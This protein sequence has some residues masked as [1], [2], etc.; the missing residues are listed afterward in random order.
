M[1]APEEQTAVRYLIQPGSPVPCGTG[2]QKVKLDTYRKRSVVW[3]FFR[4]INEGSVQCVLCNRYLHKKEHGSTTPMLRHLRL[5]HPSQVS[6]GLKG[7]IGAA[8]S[9]DPQ[10]ME[11]DGEEVFS[12]V[13]EMDNDESN[14][15]TMHDDAGSA[16]SG[17]SEGSKQRSY[18]HLVHEDDLNHIPNRHSRRRSLIWRLFEHLDNLNAARCR[19]CMKKL[20]KSGGISNLRRHLVKRHPHVLSELLSSNHQPSQA[21]NDSSVSNDTYIVAEPSP[22]PVKL[23]L[24][25]GQSHILTSLNEAEIPIIG[26]LQNQPQ[27]ES[28]QKIKETEGSNADGAEGVTVWDG[29]QKWIPVEVSLED[30]NSDVTP[31]N[32]PEDTN[33]VINDSLQEVSTQKASHSGATDDSSDKPPTKNRRRSMIWKHFDILESAEAAQCRICSRKLQCFD[34]GGTGN[35][36][37]HLSKRH[38]EAFSELG[39]NQRQQLSPH[40]NSHGGTTKNLFIK[41]EQSTVRPSLPTTGQKTPRQPEVEI[42]VF[43]MELELIEALRRTQ[44]EEA[45]ALQRQRELLEKLQTVSAREVAAEREKIESLRKAQ[46]EEAEELRRQREE[47]EKGKAELQKKWEEFNQEREKFMLLSKSTDGGSDTI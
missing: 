25:A 21:L 5:K 27:G 23:V 43:E 2:P 14:I 26:S 15:K 46:Q 47:L 37:R 20:H 3:S 38:P 4:D 1:A 12:V 8:S 6:R 31:S 17:P 10:H 32:E 44:K 24:D 36:H 34:S 42:R 11:I 19:I 33:H 45:Q 35:L 7:D 13:V 9:Q 29:V 28:V 18:A 39:S 41:P 40:T 22:T 30:G 16:V